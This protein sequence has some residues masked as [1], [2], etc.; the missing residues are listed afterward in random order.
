MAHYITN[1][2]RC[3]YYLQPAWHGLGDVLPE[4]EHLTGTE[5]L[6]R[7]RI[8]W[9][10]VLEPLVLADGCQIDE[11]QATVRD[12]LPAGNAHRYLGVVRGRCEPVDNA[13]LAE[14]V[15]ALC[16][17]SKAFVE[18]AGTLKDGRVVWFLCR[19]GDHMPAH[20]GEADGLGQSDRDVR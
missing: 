3:L 1:Y 18:S 8:N 2:D 12:D 4:S 15:D 20:G 7:C 11:W 16:D 13:E 19:L 17:G 6:N 5:A 9:R 10:T 14:V